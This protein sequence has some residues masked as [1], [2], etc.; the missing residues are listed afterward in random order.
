MGYTTN[1]LWFM[2]F[3]KN[4]IMD[5]PI[6]TWEWLVTIVNHACLSVRMGS[7]RQQVFSF[8]NSAQPETNFQDG[9]PEFPILFPMVF[10]VGF[11]FP[12]WC[13]RATIPS[14][15]LKML[16]IVKER[17]WCE[18]WRCDVI[19]WFVGGFRIFW[20]VLNHRKWGFSIIEIIQT[21]QMTRCWMGQNHFFPPQKD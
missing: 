2:F 18:R 5:D 14:A 10:Q 7:K 12:R 15:V 17:H 3:F 9:F 21:W 6:P 1:Q 13:S 4:Q 16:P 20:M 11:P 8:D 19:Q